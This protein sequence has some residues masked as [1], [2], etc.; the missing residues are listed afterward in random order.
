MKPYTIGQNGGIYFCTDSIICF[1]YVFV[2][3]QIFDIIIDSLKY[4][5]KEKGLQLVAYVIMPNHVHT[6]LGA[7][8][9][10]L[11]DILRDFKQ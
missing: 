6:I 10:N 9:A 2:E 1:T 11:S 3:I 8:D 7:N 5:Q 4:C